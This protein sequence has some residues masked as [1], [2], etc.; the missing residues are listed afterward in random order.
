[1]I[2]KIFIQMWLKFEMVF[3][4]FINWQKVEKIV[5]LEY[6]TIC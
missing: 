1:M 6:L 5:N 3:I 4:F 2:L